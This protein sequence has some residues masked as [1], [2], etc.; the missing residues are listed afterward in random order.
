MNW[1]EPVG[2][3]LSGFHIYHNSEV[4][5]FTTDTFYQEPDLPD[6]TYTYTISAVYGDYESAH[7]NQA[8]VEI[9]GN[10]SAED[11]NLPQAN[12][13]LGNYP[14]P[15]NPTTNIKFAMS[16]SGPVTIDIYNSKGMKLLTLIDETKAAGNH[17]IVWNGQDSSDQAVSSGVYFYQMRSGNY[18]K[19]QKM[20]LMK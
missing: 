9:Y 16:E 18:H 5:G 8:I 1:D 15:F 17:S 13:L 2:L 4:V 14:N 3:N 10:T 19:T 7:S 11:N 20:I 6:G 12:S